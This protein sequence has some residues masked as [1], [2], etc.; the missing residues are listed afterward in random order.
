V[1]TT[2][3]T[4]DIPPSLP[5]VLAPALTPPTPLLPQNGLNI[6]RPFRAAFPSTP[7]PSGVSLIG[8]A[9]PA[10]GTIVQ[11]DANRLLI[12]A[13]RDPALPASREDA[14]AREFVALY[15]AGGKT[16]RTFSPGVAAGRWRKLACNAC[17]GLICAVTG[18]DT[19]RVRLAGAWRGWCGRR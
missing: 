15:A 16:V 11:D 17:L 12:G 3:T 6:D 13:F 5:S 14:V 4:P 1:L 8:S 2:K 7:Q 9:K 18:L 10:P 19:G